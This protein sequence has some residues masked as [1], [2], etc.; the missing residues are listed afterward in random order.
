MKLQRLTVGCAAVV[1]LL[2]PVASGAAVLSCGVNTIDNVYVQGN[3]DDNF[4]HANKAIAK[5]NVPC[6]GVDLVFIENT[7]PMYKSFLATLLTA[8]A[9][10]VQVSVYV[11]TSQ[12]I[13][14]GTQISILQFVK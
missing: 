14:N 2:L 1:A 9:S 11:N 10:G 5:L 4:E 6:N 8:F 7:S 12:T 13:S 3:R